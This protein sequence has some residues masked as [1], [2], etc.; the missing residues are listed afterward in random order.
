[1]ENELLESTAILHGIHEEKWEEGSTR[2]NMVIDALAYTMYGSNHH[3]QLAA[4]R[5]I[6]I[7][8]TTQLGKFNP[9][10]G[11]PISVTFVYNEDC[12]HLL[13]NKTYLPKGV[14]ADKQYCEE[15]EQQ[16]NP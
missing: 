16:K 14:F 6:L 15:R 1:M 7:K 9:H 8:K 12:E 4:A 13:S 10:K 3:K 11:R 5:K 2:Y